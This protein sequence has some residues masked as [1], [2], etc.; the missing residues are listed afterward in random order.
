[1]VLA[2]QFSSKNHKL[3]GA[4]LL[5]GSIPLK[6]VFTKTY[7]SALGFPLDVSKLISELVSFLPNAI[8]VLF[9]PL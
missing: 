3:K 9:L 8:K 4:I 1:M 7:L 2:A 6:S 5:K